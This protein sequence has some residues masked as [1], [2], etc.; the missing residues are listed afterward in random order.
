MISDIPAM[1]SVKNGSAG[2]QPVILRVPLGAER[3]AVGNRR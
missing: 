1:S 2:Q 3:I